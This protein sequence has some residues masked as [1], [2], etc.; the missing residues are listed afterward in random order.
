MQIGIIGLPQSGKTTVFNALTG[1]TVQTGFARTG[2]VNRAVVRVPDRRLDFLSGL[3]EP[4]KTT[5]ATV[6]YLDLC[7]MGRGG[8]SAG[9]IDAEFLS[10]LRAVDAVLMVVRRFN[11]PNVPHPLETVD[12][13]RDA[14][15]LNDELIL[16]DLIV[17]ENRLDRIAKDTK[18]APNKDL[19]GE[20]A[21][22]LRFKQAL[23]EGRPLRSVEMT[24][25]DETLV[26]GFRFVTQK[27]LI[28]LAN[29][30]D[31]DLPDEADILKRL[32][33]YA[34]LP[35]TRLVALSAK[36]E[37]EMAELSEEDA[38]A[39][40]KDLG[41]QEPALHRLIRESYALLGLI[42]FFTV[43]KDECRA[44]TIPDG[45][46][47][48]KAAGAIH[49][50]LEKGFIRAEVTPFGELEKYGNMN[51]VKAAGRQRLEGKEYRVSDGDIIVIRFNV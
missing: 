7:G 46:T 50:D 16:A 47:A 18:R 1:S 8:I 42:S 37:A 21:V 19:D 14:D 30:A 29:I 13:A 27:P 33:K 41:I 4:K 40:R 25:K 36:I 23:E 17:V 20:K 11:D 10:Q 9:N 51:E 3:Y 38:V 35:H 24:D 15:K 12:L 34:G 49:S 6:D 45:A 28:V 31:N 22:L 5:P 39:F 44:W 2:D 48:L 32:E 43:G 26:R